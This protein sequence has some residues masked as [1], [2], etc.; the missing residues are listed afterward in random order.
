MINLTL[1]ICVYN[2]EKYILET[3]ESVIAQT[4]QDFHL[5]I[6]NDCSTDNS[7]A[8]IEK[9]FAQQSRQY[10][11][12]T[13]EKNGGI[14]NARN[15]AIAHATTKYFLFIDSDDLLEPTLVEKEYAAIMGDNDLI[16]VSCWNDFID[17]K[18]RKVHGG[19][20]LGEKTKEAF[21]E[22][23]S[24]KKLIFL[25]IHTMF[26]REYAIKAGSISIKGFPE[27]R[28][29]YQ[30]FCE[31]LALLHGAFKRNSNLL[32]KIQVPSFANTNQEQRDIA[33]CKP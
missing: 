9:F 5:L 29:R 6:V 15:F 16:G 14:A 1:A 26:N 23:A 17:E 22:K 7:V 20:F 31:D 18:G 12:I 24:K 3:L 13:F 2:A 27:D 11:I 32:H 28:P 10:E 33:L 25:P 8:V 21:V 4:M 30:D 19:T